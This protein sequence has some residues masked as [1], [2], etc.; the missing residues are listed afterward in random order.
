M[1]T[2]TTRVQDDEP[3]LTPEFLRKLERLSLVLTKAMAGKLHGERRSTKRGASVEFAD[4]RNYVHGD[5]LRYV[6]WNVYARLEKLFLKLYVEEEDL[7]V[8]LLLD[9]SRSMGF[10]T[11]RKLQAAARVIA[12]LGYIAL[13]RLDRVSVTA[14]TDRPGRRLTNIRGRGSAATL[15]SWLSGLQA[16]GHTDLARAL[17]EYALLARSPGMLVVA[18]DFLAPGIEE[19]LRALAGRRFAVTL[20]QTLAPEEIDPPISGDLRLVDS[21]T[22]DTREITITAGLLARYRRRLDAHRAYL[23]DL[24]NRYG[25]HVI[26][27]SSADPFEDLVLRALRQ[28]GVVE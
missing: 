17:R 4:F 15:F 22:G 11:P 2:P 8:H 23:A 5:D 20:V 1:T 6:D 9:T 13:C 16:E 21:E 26:S 12:S 14:I 18:S 28:R 7:H 3:L 25:M 10:G 19:G 27:T 24:G